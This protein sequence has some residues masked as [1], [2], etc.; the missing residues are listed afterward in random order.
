MKQWLLLIV[1]LPTDA[2]AL[3]MRLWRGLKSLGAGVLRDGVYALPC[4]ERCREAFLTLQSE[5]NAAPGGNAFLVDGQVSDPD[6]IIQLFDRASQYQELLETITQ[7]TKTLTALSL[8]DADKQVRK[9]RKI[10]HALQSI[11]Y[12]PR[13]SVTHQVDAVLLEL[14]EN[15]RRRQSPDE[16]R[17]LTGTLEPLSAKS[18]QGRRWATRQRPWVDRLASAWLIRRFIDPD[19]TFIWLSSPALCP[20]DAMGFDFDG[21]TFSHVGARVTFE[22]LVT[23]FQLEN[24]A[25][26]RIASLVH[27]LDVGGLEPAEAAGVR[28]ILAGLRETLPDDDQLLSAAIVIFDGLLSVYQKELS[29]YQK[30]KEHTTP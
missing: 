27:F 5:V 16:P 2:A 28:Q 26:Q 4:E 9:L 30:E 15:L 7:T 3:R 6:P 21:A 8:P 11:D 10:L 29:V 19:A 18:F 17:P 20:V 22:T 23:R 12:F 13:P 24:D 14:E 25:L 1:T